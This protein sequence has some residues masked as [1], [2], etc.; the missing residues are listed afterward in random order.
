[1]LI[2]KGFSANDVVTIKLASGEELMCRLVEETDTYYKVSKPLAVGMTN[3]GPA[4]M[5]YLF[6]INPSKDVKIF[7]PVTIIELTDDD[8]AKQYI[9]STTDIAL[10]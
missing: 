3:N 9:K 6:T 1:M 2:D 10:V 7:K 8:F 4:L 5:P